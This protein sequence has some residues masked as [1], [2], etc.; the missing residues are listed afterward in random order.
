MEKKYKY[1]IDHLLSTLSDN[2]IQNLKAYHLYYLEI[3]EELNVW[4]RIK[5][6]HHPVFGEIIRSQPDDYIDKQSQISTQLQYDAIFNNNWEPY[7]VHQVKQGIN[8]ARM[9]IEFYMWHDVIALAHNFILPN[10]SQNV[11]LESKDKMAILKGANR[12]FD[13]AMSAIAESYLDESKAIIEDQKKKQEDINKKLK[14]ALAVV[15]EKNKELE[16]FAFVASH[17]LQEPLRMV[18]S[19]LTRLNN[20]Y[21]DQLDDKAR[22]YIHFA[23]DGA[24]RMRTII[25]DLLE[26]SRVSN[27]TNE[28]G[29]VDMNELLKEVL[30]LNSKLIDE[31]EVVIE[32]NELPEIYA[33]KVSLQQ[34]LQNLIGN[35]IKYQK[36]GAKP[37]IRI[38]AVETEEHWQFSVS[39]NGIGIEPRYFD[40]IFV[41]FQ[42]LHNKTEYTG[43]GIGLALCKKIVEHHHGSIWVESEPGDGSTFHFTI[44]KQLSN[45]I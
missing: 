8:Y 45:Q 25:L 24:A 2:D 29:S 17:D 42:R 44:S 21:K 41:L 20:K 6:D 19:F 27:T 15:E 3:Q 36:S 30:Q 28:F 34:V 37:V 10:V 12:F 4:L 40:K 23:V 22:Q 1:L 26:F 31:K 11:K 18:T 16:Q 7:I 14:R 43:T 32:N 39:D 13:I 38:H 35:A 9:G 33:A 5:L